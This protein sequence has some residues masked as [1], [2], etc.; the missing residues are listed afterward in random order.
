MAVLNANYLRQLLISSFPTHYSGACMHEFVINLAK[1]NAGLI[2]AM[3][4]A[5]RLLDYGV[6]SP[7]VYFP[8]IV[9]EAMMIE[10]TETETRET[11]ETFAN[12][13]QTILQECREQPDVVLNAPWTTPVRKLDEVG[14]ARNPVLVE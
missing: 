14:A 4:F 2:K 5:K 7:T 1:A 12:I 3:S 13:M 10:P 11:L 9:P 6:H 8:L